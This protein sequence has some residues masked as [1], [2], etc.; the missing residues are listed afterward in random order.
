M[1]RLFRSLDGRDM[2]AG[3]QRWRIEVYG[4]RED[5]DSRWVQL[6]LGG[7]RHYVLTLKLGLFDGPQ[8]AFLALAEWIAN[9]ATAGGPVRHNAVVP[10][11]APRRR[12]G[13]NCSK[14]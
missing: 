11:S 1:D 7:P 2:A 13:E 5:A 14:V 10:M 3:G 8:C 12:G 9:P 6:A 4:V